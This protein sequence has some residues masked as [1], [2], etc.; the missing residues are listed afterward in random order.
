MAANSLPGTATRPSTFA[1]LVTHLTGLSIADVSAL[2]D[3]WYVIYV[4]LFS[5]LSQR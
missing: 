1:R 2:P 5:D 3:C 4:V